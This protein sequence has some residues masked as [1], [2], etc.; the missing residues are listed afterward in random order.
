MTRCNIEYCEVKITT[1]SKLA[2]LVISS[3]MIQTAVAGHDVGI[4]VGPPPG[5]DGSG[6]GILEMLFAGRGFH[7]APASG[8]DARES[9]SARGSAT[10]TRL[11]TKMARNN[12]RMSPTDKP[13]R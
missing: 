11:R 10:G 9:F 6:D 13:S 2:S 1:I 5:G 8:G 7:S 3:V 12:H 4:G